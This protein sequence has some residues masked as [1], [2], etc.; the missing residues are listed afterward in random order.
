MN[1]T[2]TSLL[3]RIKDHRDSRAWI[4][5]DAIYRPILFRFA[6]SCGL[7]EADADDVVQHCL[8]AV[9]KHI[10]DFRYDPT[11]GRFR[12][13]LRTIANNRIRSLRKKRCEANAGSSAFN[14]IPNKDTSPEEAFARLWMEEHLKHCVH[15]VRA[16]TDEPSFQAFY[17][18]V[19]DE[20][21]V[22]EVCREFQIDR[23]R[24]YKIKWRLTQKLQQYMHDLLGADE[25][26]S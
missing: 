16:A 25:S 18:Y 22:S 10:K 1:T 24:L 7:D 19:I 21:P 8:T 20:C 14:Q 23:A 6:V 9:Q 26:I 5:F 13:W 2:Q 3:I 11:R 4:E 12:S 17:K 15:R